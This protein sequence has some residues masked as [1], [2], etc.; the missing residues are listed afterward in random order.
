MQKLEGIYRIKGNQHSPR[1]KAYILKNN[2]LKIGFYH[3]WE[4]WTAYTISED[5][6]QINTAFNT[7][8]KE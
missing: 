5:K 6:T 7:Y 1:Y 2:T 3:C 8:Y 4:Y